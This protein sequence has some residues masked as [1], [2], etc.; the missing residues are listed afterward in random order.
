M[1]AAVKYSGHVSPIQPFDKKFDANFHSFENIKIWN[2]I[3]SQILNFSTKQR[4][5]NVFYRKL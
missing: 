3:F 2:Y 5:I 1:L 4:I